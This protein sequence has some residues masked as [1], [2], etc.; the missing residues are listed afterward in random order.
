MSDRIIRGGDSEAREA[1]LLGERAITP[2]TNQ[3]VCGSAVSSCSSF[4]AF[5]GFIHN[6]YK[7]PVIVLL[8]LVGFQGGL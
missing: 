4:V 1:P 8:S 7:S 3:G 6:T 5:L 2:F